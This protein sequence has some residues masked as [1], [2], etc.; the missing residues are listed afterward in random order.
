MI[1]LMENLN[2]LASFLLASTDSVSFL[3]LEVLLDFFFQYIF[4]G[5]LHFSP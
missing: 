4:S 3:K 5:F 1:E 2:L